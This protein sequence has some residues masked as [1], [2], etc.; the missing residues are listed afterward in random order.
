MSPGKLLVSTRLEGLG[1][2][3]IGGLLMLLP[4]FFVADMELQPLGVTKHIQTCFFH[5]TGEDVRFVNE[6]HDFLMILSVHRDCLYLNPS[7]FV[8]LTDKI[9]ICIF[10]SLYLP[11]NHH[12]IEM[13]CIIIVQAAPF[14]I[15]NLNKGMGCNT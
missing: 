3:L 15:T 13:A 6:M 8:C 5:G 10:I 9:S 1:D 4:H 2:H 7:I 14:G 11:W 12:P